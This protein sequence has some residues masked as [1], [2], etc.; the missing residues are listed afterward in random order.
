MPQYLRHLRPI[1]IAGASTLAACASST[2]TGTDGTSVFADADLL[3]RTFQI[4]DVAGRGVIDSSHITLTFGQDGQFSGNM[5]C[6]IVFGPYKRS[7]ADL[8][9]GAL[10][11][12]KKMCAPALMNQ[13]QA[14]LDI[15]SDVTR[16]EQDNEGALIV[17]TADGRS[18]RGFESTQPAIQ[19]YLCDDGASVEATYPTQDTARIV[20]NGQII[21]M[22][23]ARSASGARY[24]GDG[25]EWWSKG[26]D[27]AYL[28][29]LAAGETIASDKG[30]T[31]R[32]L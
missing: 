31:C 3:D 2:D 28:A 15:L 7:G 16:I 32:K 6:N 12:T 5:G 30:I 10:G 4:Q 9:F 25:W 14:I 11:A 20:Y 24:T 8:E 13:E 19:L 27:E 18:L 23:I 1:L 17:H 21:N 29:P 22:T 26:G